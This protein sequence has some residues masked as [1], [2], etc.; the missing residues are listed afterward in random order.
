[1]FDY[2]K[3][4]FSKARAEKFMTALKAQGITEIVIS[5][6]RDAFNQTQYTVDWNVD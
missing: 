6:S 2:R 1:M 3:N 5:T 4:F